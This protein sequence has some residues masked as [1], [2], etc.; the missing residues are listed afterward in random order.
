MFVSSHYHNRDWMHDGK[1]DFGHFVKTQTTPW[2]QAKSGF[3]RCLFSYFIQTSVHQLLFTKLLRRDLTHHFCTCYTD[4][5][6]SDEL[7]YK[8]QVLQPAPKPLRNNHAASALATLFASQAPTLRS[9]P[10]AAERILSVSL[11]LEV[12]TIFILQSA[13]DSLGKKIHRAVPS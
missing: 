13:Q 1:T 7:A 10:L 4:P 2:S 12:A 9:E 11:S 6:L 8:V 3:R 5:T